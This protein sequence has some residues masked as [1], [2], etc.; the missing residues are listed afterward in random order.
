MRRHASLKTLAS[1]ISRRAVQYCRPLALMR[2]SIL[3]VS[4]IHPAASDNLAGLAHE[5]SSAVKQNN[6]SPGYIVASGDLG[7]RGENQQESAR[8]LLTLAS[9]LSLTPTQIICVPGNHDVERANSL[10]PFHN[11]SNALYTVTRDSAR[12]VVSPAALYRHADVEFLL[13]NSAHH[14]NTTYGNVNCDA[15]RRVI[16]HLSPST[17]KVVVVHHN[18]I[19]VDEND[20]STITNAYE[21][22]TIVSSVGCDVVLHGHQHASLALIIGSRTKLVG[23][24]TVNFVPATNVNNQFNVVDVG[25]RTLR[26]RYHADSSTSLGFGNWDREELPW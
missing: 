26:F 7:L 9:D 18:S 2:S 25:K 22:L 3:H 20:R 23:V 21:F 14:L 17:T 8:F 10:T 12:T 13:I 1:A 4:D 19:P 5:I 6:C 24:G 11:Y 16:A 15:L